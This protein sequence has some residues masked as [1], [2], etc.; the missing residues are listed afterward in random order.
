MYD[1]IY[2]ENHDEHKDIKEIIEKEY[3]KADV[4]DGSDQIHKNRFSVEFDI[5]QE[6]WFSF[7]LKKGFALCSL[8]FQLAI[9][10]EPDKIKSMIEKL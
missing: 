6:E 8:N 4:K 10:N 7:I 5:D 2:A 3:Q 1:L 9:K